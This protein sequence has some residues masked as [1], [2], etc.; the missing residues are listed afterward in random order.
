MQAAA[1]SVRSPRAAR[2]GAAEVSALL[3]MNRERD[4]K[5]LDKARETE[6]VKA[7][8]RSERRILKNIE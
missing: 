6:A 3:G 7:V 2:A 4:S 5:E 8:S 1:R